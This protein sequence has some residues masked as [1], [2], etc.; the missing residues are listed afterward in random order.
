MYTVQVMSKERQAQ[1]QKSIEILAK[2]YK[3]YPHYQ[4][5]EKLLEKSRF[6]EEERKEYLDLYV[7]NIDRVKS[8]EEY[9]SDLF[10]DY[11]KAPPEL[12]EISNRIE[13]IKIV[14]NYSY[15]GI[16]DLIHIRN[17]AKDMTDTF[18]LIATQQ[19]EITVHRIFFIKIK[20]ELSPSEK[21]ISTIVDV[22][23]NVALQISSLQLI[24]LKYFFDPA[25]KNSLDLISRV[26]VLERADEANQILEGVILNF[27]F[28]TEYKL[29]Y[30][31]SKLSLI[32]DAANILMRLPATHLNH[33]EQITEIVTKIESSIQ[34]ISEI[35]SSDKMHLDNIEVLQNY[36][37]RLI[38]S[39]STPV[40]RIPKL[41]K[42]L[43]DLDL[44]EEDAKNSFYMNK[45]I[46]SLY[47]D[48]LALLKEFQEIDKKNR[49][50]QIE[51][52]KIVVNTKM[53]SPSVTLERKAELQKLIDDLDNIEHVDCSIISSKVV[54]SWDKLVDKFKDF[55]TADRILNKIKIMRN[56]INTFICSPSISFD[57][58]PEL[59][60][61]LNDLSSIEK[62]LNENLVLKKDEAVLWN[63]LNAFLEEFQEINKKMRLPQIEEMKI[64]INNEMN[65]PAISANKKTKLEEYL[66]D[67]DKIENHDCSIISSNILILWDNLIE[68]TK[69]EN[70]TIL[71][72]EFEDEKQKYIELINKVGQIGKAKIKK[73][74]EKKS[75]ILPALKILMQLKSDIQTSSQ[76]TDIKEKFSN[77]MTIIK[78]A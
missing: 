78:D 9:L 47:H 49:L 34:R 21:K 11:N 55:Q 58:K 52:M 71:G 10:K 16:A 38:T 68:K 14:N 53:N 73:Y 35:I 67:L 64:V 40:E 42:I 56:I 41:K 5:L 20:K 48:I 24:A 77:A 2:H 76:L 30:F 18:L 4:E 46:S 61:L 44:L 32:K 23:A 60:K 66:S 36:T 37:N 70:I 62:S 13:R 8:L 31:S 12:Y 22:N 59:E 25:Y 45:D 3:Q 17:N 72:K 27:S 43:S 69:K 26:P 74:P 29:F 6:K 1:I 65:S 15:T 39:P 51:E 7:H 54:I 19:L 50:P 33:M 57:R 63:N 28:K 75:S